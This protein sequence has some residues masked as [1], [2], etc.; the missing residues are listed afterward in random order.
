MC[1]FQQP[2]L[3]GGNITIQRDSFGQTGGVNIERFTLKN[4]HDV[5]MQVI[6]YGATWT[7]LHVPD[8]NGAVSDVVLGY[9]DIQGYVNG[10]SS[11]GATIGRVA[12]RI[13][14]ARFT[15]D[16]TTYDTPK[17]ERGKQTLHGGDPSFSKFIWTPKVGPGFVEFAYRSPDGENGFPG[18]MDIT[19]RYTLTNKNEIIIDF[20]ATTD[21][22]TP[23]NMCNHAYF[24]LA[25]Q[26]N[27]T[28]TDHK[29]AIYADSYLPV[30]AELI[31]S[32]VIAPVQGTQFD[33]RQ[34]TLLS[35]ARL[36]SIP[37]GGYDHNFC[38]NGTT[39]LKYMARVVHEASGRVLEVLSDQPGVQLYSSIHFGS[40]EEIGKGGVRYP[41]FAALC[42]ETQNYPDAI[43]NENFP[44]SVLRPGSVYK[45]RVI[46]KF[47][48]LTGSS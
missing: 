15:I 46:Y 30:D 29:I 28:M 23:I 26:G 21:K 8:R 38:V 48:T 10:V 9:D 18:T 6:S 32:G 40:T 35:N 33:L 12:N 19:T 24:N 42:L 44:D 37:G 1:F 7:T 39:G 45:H 22:A 2:A 34:P 27:R 3:G 16:G 14:N 25:G 20:E 13:S 47:S 36:A 31:P 41:Q 11:I 17:N 5:T 43:N 4:D